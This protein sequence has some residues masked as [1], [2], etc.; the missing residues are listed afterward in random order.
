MLEVV[1]GFRN[2]DEGPS[3]FSNTG[4][5]LTEIRAVCEDSNGEIFRERWSDRFCERVC[6]AGFGVSCNNNAI[7]QCYRELSF[8][9]D[10][11]SIEKGTA[12]LYSGF[13]RGNFN[14]R[15]QSVGLN[16][17]GTGIRDCANSDLPSTCYSGGF[18]PYS[19][20]HRGPYYVRNHYGDDYR[21]HLFEGVIEHARGL[22]A[23]RYLSNPISSTD[24]DLLADFTRGEYQ[25]RPLDGQFTIRV[26]DEPGVSFSAIEDVQ[27]VLN[28]QY[29]TR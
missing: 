24:K 8:Y 16:F 7:E 6:P 10:Q 9:I 21:A 28:Y 18:V 29:W 4:A 27:V 22:A 17:V 3:T 23:E 2:A 19:L 5:A 26:W 25:G 14:Y 20:Y 15:L 1:S 11:A 13:A 12:L